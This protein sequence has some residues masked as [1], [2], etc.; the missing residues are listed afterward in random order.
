[1]AGGAARRARGKGEVIVAGE[2]ELPYR[3]VDRANQGWHGGPD[4]ESG[5]RYTADWGAQRGLEDRTYEE[6]L[7]SR[8]PLRPVLPLTGD[9]RAELELL[10]RAAGRKAI[11]TLAAAL[12]Q[13]FYELRTECEGLRLGRDAYGFAKR[14]LK[15]GREGSW[16][17]EVLIDVVL[18]GNSLNLAKAKPGDA[19]ADVA[20][21]R[22]AGPSRRVDPRVRAALAGIIKRWVTAPDRYTEVAETLASAVSRYCDA[23]GGARGW[24]LAA[25]QWLQP[26]SL[27][28][29]DFA[30][31]YRLFYSQS[32]HFDSALLLPSMRWGTPES[33]GIAHGSSVSP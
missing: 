27:A 25:D 13:V 9:D 21:R 4:E 23:H 31:C 5:S 28:Q 29:D 3:V 12:E 15:A 10:L 8:G 22:A 32:E 19:L 17:S 26:G 30:A 18:L 16:E 33:C 1:M 7:A 2:I 11:G 24:Q 6:L 20:A 14:T